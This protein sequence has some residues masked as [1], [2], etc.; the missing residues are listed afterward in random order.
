MMTNTAQ[1]ALRRSTENDIQLSKNITQT[2][3]FVLS[4]T[5]SPKLSLHF[6][7]GVRDSNSNK[8]L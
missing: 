1:F 8:F 5:M 7:Q 3:D 2:P 6:N 4:P